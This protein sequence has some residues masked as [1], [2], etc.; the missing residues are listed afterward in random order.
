MK[1]CI[2]V[3]ADFCWQRDM[4]R[5]GATAERLNQNTRTLKLLR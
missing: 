1:Y 2:Q 4:R 3:Q 5:Y